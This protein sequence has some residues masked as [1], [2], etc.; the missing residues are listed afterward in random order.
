MQRPAS[1]GLP[2]LTSTTSASLGGVRPGDGAMQGG[3]TVQ[4]GT[5]G[6]FHTHRESNKPDETLARNDGE[7]EHSRPDLGSSSF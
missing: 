2:V 7:P 4:S 1:A 6:F 3:G 5:T